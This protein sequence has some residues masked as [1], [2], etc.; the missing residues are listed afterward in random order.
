MQ[1]S[2][3]TGAISYIAGAALAAVIMPNVCRAEKLPE[4]LINFTAAAKFCNYF[5]KKHILSS[6]FQAEMLAL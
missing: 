1:F 2:N 6:S 3:V 5:F 4:S